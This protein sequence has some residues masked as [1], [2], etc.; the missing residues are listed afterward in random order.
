MGKQRELT[1][2]QQFT[3]GP[4]SDCPTVTIHAGK[5]FKAL[6]VSGAAI[7]LMHTSMHNLSE[8]CY[9]TYVLPATMSLWTDN[10]SIPRTVFISPFS[11]Y[12]NLKV[13]FGLMQV[14]AY[15]LELMNK[16]LKDLSFAKAYLEDI[17]I[18]STTTEHLKHLQEMLHKL[19]D[20]K[21]SMRL[22][23]CHV[24]PKK[25]SIWVTF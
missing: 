13:P 15:F 7:S 23:E 14:P 2:P 12:E 11:K 3:I 16:V 17:I 20:A 6:I 5:H 10:A 21:L 18:F 19:W 1:Q 25:F 8:D 9:K 4:I 24:L 22:S